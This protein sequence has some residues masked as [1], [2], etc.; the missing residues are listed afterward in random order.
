MPRVWPAENGIEN[1]AGAEVT[2]GWFRHLPY[3]P[4]AGRLLAPDD[5]APGAAPVA[6]IR[7]SL[8]QRRYH[9]DPAAVGA[10]VDVAGVP[11]A[12]DALGRPDE[13]AKIMVVPGSGDVDRHA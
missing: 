13:H 2:P 12:F 8:W 5:G 6:L 9:G 4:V 7:E 3:R 1:V 11:D 10:V